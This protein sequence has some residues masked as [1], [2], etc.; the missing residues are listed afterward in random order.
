MQDL[1]KRGLHG[2]GA[3]DSGVCWAKLPIIRREADAGSLRGSHA[4]ALSGRVDLNPS[5]MGRLPETACWGRGWKWTA[6]GDIG[7]T[8]DYRW[9]FPSASSDRQR[10]F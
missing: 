5:T 6:G 1:P 4:R 9:Q 3:G 10:H 8:Q 7:C 2:E